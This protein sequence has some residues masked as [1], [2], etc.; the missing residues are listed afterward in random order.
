MM[1]R[2]F[3]IIIL[4]VAGGLLITSPFLKVGLI[5][6][7]SSYFD[8]EQ[9]SA[10][11]LNKNN[12]RDASFD[13]SKIQHPTFYETVKAGMNANSK[14]VI[15]QIRVDS[16]GINL[17]ILKGT[18]RANLL[19]GAT[20]MR[21]D[22]K[23]GEGNYPLAGHHMRRQSLLF[24][25]LLQ[26]KNGALVVMTDLKNDYVY[27]VTSHRTISDEESKV[28]VIHETREKR[29]TLITC[30]RTTQTDRWLV[31]QGKLIRVTPHNG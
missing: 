25:P 20:T 6:I 10:D 11:Q 18:T 12:Q 16:V 19:V 2:R 7:L 13:F 14:A 31:V 27:K 30:D 9:M 4:I 17:P 8:A 3:F 21:P 22:Q 5:S 23:M 26:I 15:G 1:W 29:M 28:K 24:G